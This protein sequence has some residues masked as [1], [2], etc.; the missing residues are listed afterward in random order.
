MK[1]VSPNQFRLGNCERFIKKSF[2]AKVAT[3]F[4]VNIGVAMVGI[5]DD[6][7]ANVNPF[8]RKSYIHL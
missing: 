3:D 4:H 8:G 5:G 1:L 7:F 2:A 6:T